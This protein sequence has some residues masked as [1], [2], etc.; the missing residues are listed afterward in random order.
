MASLTRFTPA[1]WRAL[2]ALHHWGHNRNASSWRPLRSLLS[3]QDA[4]VEDLQVLAANGLCAVAP[5]GA[6]NSA[7]PDIIPADKVDWS[8]AAGT[9]KWM[10]ILRITSKGAHAMRNQAEIMICH[11]INR[12]ARGAGRKYPAV[13]MARSAGLS[14]TDFTT[15]YKQMVDAGMARLYTADGEE[16]TAQQITKIKNLLDPQAGYRCGLTQK[17]TAYCPRW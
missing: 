12:P 5:A 17:G 7:N 15:V 14:A 9:R 1:Q 13:D 10:Y 16:L 4:S 6:Q 2:G 3:K 11:S 8:A